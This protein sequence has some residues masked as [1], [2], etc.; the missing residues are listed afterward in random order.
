MRIYIKKVVNGILEYLKILYKNIWN[1]MV[2]IIRGVL[3]KDFGCMRY[4]KL[5]LE[6]MIIYLNLK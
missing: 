6:K 4:W 2:K 3:E 1:N 5:G